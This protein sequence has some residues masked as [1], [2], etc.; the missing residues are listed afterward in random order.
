M[1][2]IPLPLSVLYRNP[3]EMI[4]SIPKNHYRPS[5]L[6][7]QNQNT[8]GFGS[9]FN[10]FELKEEFRAE[11]NCNGRWNAR[12]VV[13]NNRRD[14]GHAAEASGQNVALNIRKGMPICFEGE[15]EE[16]NS[17]YLW[18]LLLLCGCWIHRLCACNNSI[19]SFSIYMCYP[20][21]AVSI[22][23]PSIVGSGW[24]NGGRA[25]SLSRI[26]HFNY[27]RKL[28]REGQIINSSRSLPSL[29]PRRLFHLARFVKLRVM[30][31]LLFFFSNKIKTE[32]ERNPPLS[33]HPV[34]SDDDVLLY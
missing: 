29:F 28:Q 23:S 26:L 32:K 20:K 9:F 5:I 2:E 18:L 31:F 1:D 16:G 8:T 10:I 3:I 34:A 24:G 4:H 13:S 14:V 19:R 17:F 27:N 22:L 15:G 25:R 30:N 21:L 6:T 7:C 33:L 11:D 12:R